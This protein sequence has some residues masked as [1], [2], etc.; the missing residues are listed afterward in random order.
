MWLGMGNADPCPGDWQH[1]ATG[2]NHK[3]S[4][5]SGPSGLLQLLFG[6]CTNVCGSLGASPQDA[7]GEQVRWLQGKQEKLEWTAQAKEALDKLK[8][9]Q[10][11]QLGLF[12]VDPDKGLV[13]R[14]DVSDYAV[15]AVLEQVRCDGT[16]VPVVFWIR[17]L[18]EGRL[19]TWTARE[20]ETYAILCAL[21]KWSSH[22]GLQ[23]LVVCTD[24]QSLRSW[25]REH[26]DTPSGPAV[27]RT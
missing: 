14:T 7:T 21:R 26:G 27:R 16:H 24:H 5:H 15:G 23:P 8:E 4:V 6:I 17:V 19:R 13:L 22:I 18:A 2:K 10:L 12:L 1:Y 20:K 9:R 11:S 25:H 3:P